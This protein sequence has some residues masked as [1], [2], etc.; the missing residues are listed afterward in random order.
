M[1]DVTATSP[2]PYARFRFRF[3]TRMDPRGATNGGPSLGFGFT[4]YAEKPPI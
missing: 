1:S 2:K 3:N 4:P